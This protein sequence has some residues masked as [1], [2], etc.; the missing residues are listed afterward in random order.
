M[1]L[2]ASPAVESRKSTAGQASSGT[3]AVDELVRLY[4]DSLAAY[5]ADPD[6]AKKLADTREKFALT[7][8][9]NAIF[10]LDEVLTQ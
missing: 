8:V 10:N 3:H 6:S 5:D 2:L 1:P 9:A 4:D 7:V